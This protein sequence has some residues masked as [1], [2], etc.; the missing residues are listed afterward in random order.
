[1]KYLKPLRACFAGLALVTVVGCAGT[2]TKESTGEYIDDS[3]ITTRVKTA[4]IR[5]EQVKA[6]EVNVETFKGVVQLSGFVS[7]RAAM[8]RAVEIARGI[9][10]VTSVKNDMQIR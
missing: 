6:G 9:N 8:A 4:L 10:G 7:T 3:V 2:A 5:D 1:M